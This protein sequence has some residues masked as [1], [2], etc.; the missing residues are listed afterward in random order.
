MARQAENVLLDAR[1]ADSPKL[2]RF[3][4]DQKKQFW[5]IGSHHFSNYLGTGRK[6]LSAH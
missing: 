4:L 5:N 6:R 2:Y 3:Y 1:I